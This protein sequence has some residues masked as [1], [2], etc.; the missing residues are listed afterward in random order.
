MYKSDLEWLKGIS[1]SPSGSLEAEKNKRASHI[2]SDKFYRQHPDTLQFTS[3]IDSMPM[4]LAKHNSEVMNHV[5]CIH[6]LSL[7][8][9][10]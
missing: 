2:L 6:F 7:K 8:K 5:S 1:W 9:K 10:S 3:P 4:T